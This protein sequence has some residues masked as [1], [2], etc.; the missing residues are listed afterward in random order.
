VTAREPKASDISDAEL[1]AAVRATQGMHGVARWSSLWDVQ[2]ALEHWPAKV[3]TAKLRS[4]IKR[5]L[6]R[7]CG[8]GCRG[9]F[10]LVD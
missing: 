10:E 8:C 7:G 6:L 3:V 2:R 9:D 5:K 1:L 4:A